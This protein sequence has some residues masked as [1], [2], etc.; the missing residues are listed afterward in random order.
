MKFEIRSKIMGTEQR[1]LKRQQTTKVRLLHTSLCFACGTQG[2]YTN[3][4]WSTLLL[5]KLKSTKS[6]RL[7]STEKKTHAIRLL[8]AANIKHQFTIKLRDQLYL[9]TPSTRAVLEKL[10]CSQLVKKLPIFYGTLRFHSALSAHHVSLSWTRSVQPMIPRSTSSRVV[11]ILSSHPRLD[12]QSGLF[13]SVLHTIT[14]YAPFLFPHTCYMPR[15][16]IFLDLIFGEY[17]NSTCSFSL[18]LCY[19][20][21]LLG[22]Y[23]LLGTLFSNTPPMFLCRCERPFTPIQNNR[24]IIILLILTSHYFF[25]GG[26]RLNVF[27][28]RLGIVQQL[29]WRLVIIIN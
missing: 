29:A 12:F 9:H 3:K 16:P 1:K 18:H 6:R 22:P 27:T 19:T 10:T 20:L 17:T 11:L 15:Y 4:Q 7:L 2:K 24:Q 5:E 8:N 13:S 21:S 25:F 14:L 23:I 28:L 26:G